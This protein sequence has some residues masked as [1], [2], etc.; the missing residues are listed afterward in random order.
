LTIIDPHAGTNTSDYALSISVP[1]GGAVASTNHTVKFGDGISATVG[2]NTRGFGV[3]LF[4]GSGYYSLGNVLVD[5]PI[6]T[7][8]FV[9]TL[10]TIGILGNLV[11]NQGEYQTVSSITYI[12]GNITN[13]G[14]LTAASTLNLATWTNGA[15]SAA[16]VA[17]T[18]SGTGTFRNLAA[19][20]TASLTSLTVNNTN[21][22]GVTL[23]VPLSVSG[24]LTLTAGKVNTT[25]TNLLT[26]GIATAAGTLS[27]GSSTAYIT[28]P[29]A[30]II[31]SGNT[32]TS[33]IVY[34][35]GKTAY[36]PISL[37]PETTAVTN[38]KAEAF[39]T[40]S[41]TVSATIQNLSA[42]RRWEAPLVSGT[43]TTI[44]VR[45]GD[46]AITNVNFPVIAPT[47]SGIYDSLFG[48]TGTYA[49]GTPNTTQSTT[50][51]ATAS[52]TGFLS[53]A[54]IASALGTIEIGSNEKAIQ[55]YP[56]PFADVLNIS[57]INNVK[58]ISI[59]DIAGRL[60]KTFDKPNATLHL[61]E[62]N[63]GMYLVVLNMKDGSKQTIKAIK[64]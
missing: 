38:M 45:L 42:T 58:S 3:Y 7:N 56:N 55:V 6:G 14:T 29:F 52:Y 36:A 32:N 21:A 26:L 12:A 17:Q 24:T 18:I 9:S 62:L 33:Y 40:N 63:S 10:S 37:A 53:Y 2:G 13:N 41:G 48:T 44:N 19:S 25:S 22:S 35:V 64:K 60:V 20:P 39:D 23:N 57:D 28:G 46:N 54:E 11:I 50:A 49:A 31:A 16:T 1:S 59:V 8:R 43:F 47:A 5:A 27:G 30:R 34:P 51:L 4:P 15:A 61:G